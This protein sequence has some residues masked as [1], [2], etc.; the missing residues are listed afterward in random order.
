M[1]QRE[2]LAAVATTWKWR[3]RA[4]SAGT[5]VNV[6]NLADST[7]D[8][9]CAR[10]D[11]GLHRLLG[12]RLAHDASTA[13]TMSAMSFGEKERSSVPVGSAISAG[14]TCCGS[15]RAAEV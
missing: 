12:G 15:S 8:C 9:R 10:L 4:E 2:T 6:G 5:T 3:A 1:A 11:I 14:V 13:A 7:C